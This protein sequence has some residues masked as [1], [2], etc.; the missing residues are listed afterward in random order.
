THEVQGTRAPLVREVAIPRAEGEP[1][2]L[3]HDR[4]ADDVDGR[5][6]ILDHPANQNQL[7]IIL[8]P[9]DGHIRRNDAEELRDYGENAAKVTGSAAAAEAI[10]SALGDDRYPRLAIRIHL[11]R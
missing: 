11:T 3:A 10:G 5:A 2:R 7:L 6:Q 8:A 4:S 9:E 1:V